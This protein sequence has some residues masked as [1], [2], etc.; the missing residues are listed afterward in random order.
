MNSSLIFLSRSVDQEL[1]SWLKWLLCHS[2]H[3]TGLELPAECSLLRLPLGRFSR[4]RP[5]NT[6]F[7]GSVRQNVP[8]VRTVNKPFLCIND[9]E[10]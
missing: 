6:S 2:A 4:A 9:I 8:S 10:R 3:S 7:K 5:H 1:V